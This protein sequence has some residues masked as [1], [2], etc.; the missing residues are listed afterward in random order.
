MAFPCT[1]PPT[2]LNQASPLFTSLCKRRRAWMCQDM[3]GSSTEERRPKLSRGKQSTHFPALFLTT[4]LAYD[5]PQVR[6][7]GVTPFPSVR[8]VS[9]KNHLADTGRMV[10][11]N[12]YV[13]L[14]LHLP[15]MLTPT[16]RHLLGSPGWRALHCALSEEKKSLMCHINPRAALRFLL[17]EMLNI[18]LY[19]NC[20]SKGIVVSCLTH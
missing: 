12:R 4:T 14:E 10:W 20:L 2:S 17:N 1:P 16:R 5:V 13:F 7:E 3:L 6:S 9:Q 15:Q 8:L 18:V 19:A 11:G